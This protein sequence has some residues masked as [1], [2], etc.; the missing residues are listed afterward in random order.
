MTNQEKR[1]STRSKVYAAELQVRAAVEKAQTAGG[2]DFFGSMLPPPRERGFRS[3]TEIEIYLKAAL[4]DPEVVARFGA[5]PVPRLRLGNSE[6]T[7]SYRAENREILMPQSGWAWRELVVLHELAHHVAA[8]KYPRAAGHGPEFAAIYCQLVGHQMGHATELLLRAALD[9][10][11][12]K[13]G[14]LT[15]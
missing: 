14:A 10:Q 2:V 8:M 7:S 11:R 15:E 12:V 3:L 4:L 6:D 1:D 5:L 9:G 13:V